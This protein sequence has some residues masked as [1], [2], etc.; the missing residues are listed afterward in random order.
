M[1]LY[2]KTT[3]MSS[4]LQAEGGYYKLLH[5]EPDSSRNPQIAHA[6]HSTPQA[7]KLLDHKVLCIVAEQPAER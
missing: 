7:G 3:T 4:L 6:A 2:T 1:M 5:L